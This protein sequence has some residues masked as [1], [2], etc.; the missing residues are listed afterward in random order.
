MLPTPPRERHKVDWR[1]ERHREAE[2]EDGRRRRDAA[3]ARMR[4]LEAQHREDERR[5]YLFNCTHRGHTG[6]PSIIEPTYT[7][8]ACPTCGRAFY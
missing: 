5:L 7:R 2:R 4:E 6:I 8:P 3:V 1:D